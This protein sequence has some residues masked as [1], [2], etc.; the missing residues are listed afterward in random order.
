[1]RFWLTALLLFTLTAAQADYAGLVRCGAVQ[2]SHRP[3][4]WV[5][6]VGQRVA[7]ATPLGAC[8]VHLVEG[9]S[10][11]ACWLG[12]GVL[13]VSEGLLDLGLCEDELAGVLAHELAH[14]VEG[15]HVRQAAAFQLRAAACPSE[16]LRREAARERAANHADEFRADELGR[17]FAVAAGYRADGLARALARLQR[18]GCGA[19]ATATHP[20]LAER[21]LRL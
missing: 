13:W 14:G 19:V 21:L 8:E 9:P 17:T 16:D 20:S 1:M 18:D 12:D 11:E 7:A 10:P 15:H 2:P 4:G 6:S 5:N 3:A